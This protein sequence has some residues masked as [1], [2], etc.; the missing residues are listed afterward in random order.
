MPLDIFPSG[1]LGSV[2]T[3]KTFTPDQSGD[4]SGALVDIKTRE[5]P[6]GRQV[7]IG[8][9]AGFNSAVTGQ[10]IA[11]A[12]TVSGDLVRQRRQ[13]PRPP[14][15]RCRS[16]RPLHGEPGATQRPHR[17]LPECVEPE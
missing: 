7:N 12:P 10:N 11:K 6:A 15:G 9:S 8:V 1:L 14:G 13:D 17:L 3:I 2:T 4:F 5:F 16:R